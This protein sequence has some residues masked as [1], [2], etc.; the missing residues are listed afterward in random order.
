MLRSHTQGNSI[1]KISHCRLPSLAQRH[2]HHPSVDGRH[3]S[4]LPA[5]SR[6]EARIYPLCLDAFAP[7]D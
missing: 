6:P 7:I 4:P 5:D 2:P 3:L 1:V